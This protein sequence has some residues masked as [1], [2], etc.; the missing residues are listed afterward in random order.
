MSGPADPDTDMVMDLA[1]LDQILSEEIG[2]RLEGRALHREVSEFNA[3][4]TLPTCEAL[5]RDLFTRIQTRLPPGVVLER[6]RVAEDIG[7]SAECSRA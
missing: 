5:A 6:V 7:L 1:T 2:S 3:G 4:R